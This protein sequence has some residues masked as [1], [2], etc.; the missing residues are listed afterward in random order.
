ME[1]T[2]DLV[3]RFRHYLEKSD[4]Q[5]QNHVD[6]VNLYSFYQELIAIKNEVRLESR[7]VK[8]GFADLHTI[9]NNDNSSGKGN[10]AAAGHCTEN[11][12]L[13]LI[14]LDGLLDI[15][16]RIRS[17][18]QALPENP[19]PKR[20]FG[21]F[22]GS[23]KE[24]KLIDS[25][26]TGQQMLLDRILD[27]LS[28]WDVRPL[29]VL[30]KTFDPHCMRALESDALSGVADGAVTA[31]MRTGFLHQDKVLRLAD[32]RVNRLSESCS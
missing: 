6:R 32:V 11:E 9:L 27:L 8:K 16:D 28:T 30:E 15:H 17:S 19:P 7:L 23:N 4:D 24:Q 26:R 18:I 12:E 25:M 22:C 29:D 1:T 31:E 20:W 14:L 13:P 10:Q 21:L 2:D 3:D 5:R